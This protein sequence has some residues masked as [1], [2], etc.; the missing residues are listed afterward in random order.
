[1]LSCSLSLRHTVSQL[2]T[3]EG[4]LSYRAERPAGFLNSRHRNISDLLLLF[5]YQRF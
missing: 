1:M 2:G 4:S 5:T 3:Y